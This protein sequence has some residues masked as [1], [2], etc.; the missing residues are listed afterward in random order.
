MVEGEEGG[1]ISCMRQPFKLLKKSE[2]SPPESSFSFPLWRGVARQMILILLSWGSWKL[3]EPAIQLQSLWLWEPLIWISI[4]FSNPFE[5]KYVVLQLQPNRCLRDFF[6]Q[7]FCIIIVVLLLHKNFTLL[8][9]LKYFKIIMLSREI[10]ST[11][12]N[13]TN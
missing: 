13:H 12:L 5:K 7:Q 3:D 11:N 1:I 9:Y 10:V 2:E 6:K 8:K 4:S